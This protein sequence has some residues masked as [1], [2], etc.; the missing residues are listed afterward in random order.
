[1][2]M[3]QAFIDASSTS[4]QNF[5]HSIYYT[6]KQLVLL[7]PSSFPKVDRVERPLVDQQWS[8]LDPSSPWM[9]FILSDVYSGRE[10]A[11]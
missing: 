10:L 8:I 3:G 1:M 9:R 6:Q 11:P 4:S 5:R 2:F 7:Q